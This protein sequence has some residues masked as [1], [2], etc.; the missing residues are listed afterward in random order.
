MLQ[1]IDQGK[2][3]ALAAVV[4]ITLSAC[5]G[6][7]ETNSSPDQVALDAITNPQ[8]LAAVTTVRD[9]TLKYRDVNVALKDG[10]VATTVC[11]SSSYGAMGMHYN[12]RSLLGVIPGSTPLNGADS[13]IDLSR[14]EVLLYEPSASGPRLVAV[15]FVVF[16]SA[17]DAVHTSRPTLAGVPFDQRFGSNA[18]GISNHYELHVWLYRNNSFGMFSPYNPAVTC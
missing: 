14:P 15:E 11:E 1:K 13:V 17:W 18:H 9:A 2:R 5:G 16:A 7:T 3:A 6:P 10:Y 8:L 12:N 4:L